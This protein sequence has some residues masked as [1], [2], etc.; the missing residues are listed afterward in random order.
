MPRELSVKELS[1]ISYLLFYHNSFDRCV[2]P[3]NDVDEEKFGL[4]VEY[5]EDKKD[6]DN[7]NL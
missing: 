2:I 7:E 3:D 5:G 4:N 1:F 6:E